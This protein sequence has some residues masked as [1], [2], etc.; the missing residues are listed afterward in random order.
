MD[1]KTQ[2]PDKKNQAFAKQ[3]NRV[4]TYAALFLLVLVSAILF[5][6]GVEALKEIL[7]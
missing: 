6:M 3:W 1:N 2:M 7:G 4:K 5:L